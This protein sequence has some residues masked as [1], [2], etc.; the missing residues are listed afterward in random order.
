MKG[1]GHVYMA[2]VMLAVLENPRERPKFP[3]INYNNFHVPDIVKNSIL[4]FPSYFRAGAVGPDFFP[5]LIFGQTFIHPIGSGGWLKVMHDELLTIPP[6]TKQQSQAIAFYAGYMMHYAG[7]M[8]THYYINQYAKGWFP[9]LGEIKEDLESASIKR[10]KR[11]I[12]NI[13]IIVRHVAIEKYL[14][15][16]IEEQLKNHKLLFEKTLDIPVD[17]L[18]RCFA[19]GQIK[20]RMTR[21][22]EESEKDIDKAILATY[23]GY[24]EDLYEGGKGIGNLKR[25]EER[26]ES[27]LKLWRDIAYGTLTKGT[28][29]TF[30]DLKMELATQLVALTSENEKEQIEAEDFLDGLN[31]FLGIMDIGIRIPVLS[32]LLDV[33]KEAIKDGLKSVAYPYIIDACSII[34][35]KPK[36]QLKDFDSAVEAVKERFKCVKDILNDPEIFEENK[37][38][39]FSDK[40]LL[41][42]GKM[43]TTLK[44]SKLDFTHFVNA[45]KMGYLALLGADELNRL[46]SKYD[47]SWSKY[48]L[49]YNTSIGISSFVVFVSTS[50]SKF[51]GTNRNVTLTIYDKNGKDIEKL[52]IKGVNYLQLASTHRLTFPAKSTIP[53][54]KIDHFV[55]SVTGKDLWLGNYVS[56]MDG[57]TN[58]ELAS[59]VGGRLDYKSE[60][61]LKVP[62]NYEY[63][64]EA[65]PYSAKI[66]T[67]CVEIHTANERNAGTNNDVFFEVYSQGRRQCCVLLDKSGYD[68][69]EQNDLDTYTVHLPVPLSY[70]EIDY[71]VLS[72]NGDDAWKVD[73]V[74]IYDEDS[75]EVVSHCVMKKKI[76]KKGEIIPKGDSTLPSD[77]DVDSYA[78]KQDEEQDAMVDAV[79]V[80]IKTAD[81]WWAGTNDDIF[82]KIFYA[83]ENNKSY[84]IKTELDTSWH[85][86]FERG[87]TDTFIIKLPKSIPLKKFSHFELYK[88]GSDDWTI[89]SVIVQRLSGGVPFPFGQYN[90][91][92]ELDSESDIITITALK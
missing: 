83:G 60:I 72:K 73:S 51:A 37:K 89:K 39:H 29:D 24:M 28:Y 49:N 91:Q 33:I 15:D 16:Y 50:I 4:K 5:D 55:L 42:W 68:D 23:A 75:E 18:K 27:W 74:I 88:K 43:G 87:D 9:S 7:D 81:K 52:K 40:L 53:L 65:V 78:P 90:N 17:Y 3:N 13:Y 79:K 57:A 86:D 54:S 41:E 1:K 6:E 67:L 84:Y 77:T 30:D 11:A 62:K 44:L 63:H 25:N 10:I 66:F 26:I 14:D 58:V 69:F 71:F 38:G 32:N 36:S 46:M 34:S 12:E 64:Y 35:G 80:S 70:S 61:V 20:E 48:Y 47:S 19:N 21:I 59:W 22:N 8:F 76:G 85:D 82:F 45:C 2:N 92:I 31:D 56:V